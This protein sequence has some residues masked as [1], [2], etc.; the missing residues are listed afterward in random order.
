MTNTGG[1]GLIGTEH[2]IVVAHA[3]TTTTGRLSHHGNPTRVGRASLPGGAGTN[4]DFGVDGHYVLILETGGALVERSISATVTA[5]AG[6]GARVRAW[7]LER[8]GVLKPPP[9]LMALSDRVV[10]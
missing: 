7:L 6:S 3:L 8:L 4:L 1:F 10:A 9:W 2:D 5:G